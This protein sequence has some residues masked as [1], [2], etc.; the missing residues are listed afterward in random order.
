M[1]SFVRNAGFA[2]LI[3]A[4]GLG[5]ATSCR[6]APAPEPMV[7]PQTERV[8][9]ATPSRTATDTVCFRQT[10]I[11]FQLQFQTLR[12][13]QKNPAYGRESVVAAFG[14]GEHSQ[15][16]PGFVLWMSSAGKIGQLPNRGIY[17]TDSSGSL[18]VT[19]AVVDTASLNPLERPIGMVQI[20]LPLKPRWIWW[21]D[22]VIAPRRDRLVTG[23]RGPPPRITATALSGGDSLYVT[24]VGL[25]Q[26][27]GLYLT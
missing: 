4:S 15:F 25:G 16:V 20:E 26:R 23:M 9:T 24:A 2:L 14:E 13:F 1:P 6:S 3:I 19:I 10:G 18:P 21:V 11:S 5:M 12:A 8:V 22:V 17:P 27:C 7:V